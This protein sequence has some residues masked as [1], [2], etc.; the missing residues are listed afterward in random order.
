MALNPGYTLMMPCATL[1]KR[2]ACQSLLAACCLRQAVNAL[3]LVLTPF[4]SWSL[5]RLFL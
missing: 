1:E 2:V 5:W 4:T 3:S